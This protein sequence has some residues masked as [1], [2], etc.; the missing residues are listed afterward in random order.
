MSYWLHLHWGVDTALAMI[1]MKLMIL[2]ILM[3]LLTKVAPQNVIMLF[4]VRRGCYCACVCVFQS[5]FLCVFY[6]CRNHF[7]LII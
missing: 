7:Q 4:N 2:R 6:F 3:I 5:Y 1:I